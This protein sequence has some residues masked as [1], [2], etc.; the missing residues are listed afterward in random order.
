MPLAY[1]HRDRIDYIASA[2]GHP[3]YIDKA[4]RGTRLDY[5]R[6]SV[7]VGAIERSLKNLS[8]N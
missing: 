2:V 4:T 1:Y 6:V 7:E 8:C 3:L 5:A